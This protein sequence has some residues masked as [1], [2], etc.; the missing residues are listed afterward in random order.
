MELS[1]RDSRRKVLI[2]SSGY[3]KCVK[4]ERVALRMACTLQPLEESSTITSTSMPIIDL[5]YSISIIENVEFHQ[6]SD[7]NRVRYSSLL[8]CIKSLF[9]FL[10]LFLLIANL[11]LEVKLFLRLSYLSIN[12]ARFCLRLAYSACFS[13]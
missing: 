8:E 5:I 2:L 11:E 9:P 12:I 13:S 4:K 1:S 3:G 10:Y 6:I 7:S